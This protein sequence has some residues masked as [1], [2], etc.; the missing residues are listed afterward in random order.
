V[1]VTELNPRL[2][3][4]FISKVGQANPDDVLRRIMEENPGASQSVTW[5]I[6]R[7]EILKSDEMVEMCLLYYHVNARGRLERL[8]PRPTPRPKKPK[9]PQTERKVRVTA[10]VTRV[11]ERLIL[12]HVMPNGLR[13]RDCTFGYA[14]EV[15]GK[16][17]R[18]G[19]MGDPNEIIGQVMS[20]AQADAAWAEIDPVT[21]EIAQAP[22]FSMA[23]MAKWIRR[24][25]PAYGQAE[26]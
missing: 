13:L 22:S 15:G 2:G 24:A 6:F 1:S 11:K 25:V 20:G 5:S 4:P 8:A 7:D 14:L 26:N 10:A 19:E 9:V 16:F 18:L 21:T 3:A 23:R 12:D 17:A